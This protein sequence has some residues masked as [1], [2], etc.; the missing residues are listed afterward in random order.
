MTA[1]GAAWE[2][3]LDALHDSYARRGLAWIARCHPPRRLNRT[4]PP[5]YIGCLGGGRAFAADAKDS[6]TGRQPIVARHQAI[7]LGAV[8]ARAGVACLLVR[9]RGQPLLVLWADVSADWWARRAMP[10]LS[11]GRPFDAAPEGPG[12]LAC[13]ER[14]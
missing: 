3:T 1:R 7:D 12:W 4:G 11:V 2:G 9:W 5:D 13:V 10:I 8:E 6:T 14:T